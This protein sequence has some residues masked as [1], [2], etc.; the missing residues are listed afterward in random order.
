MA[1]IVGSK[2]VPKDRVDSQSPS[3][4]LYNFYTKKWRRTCLDIGSQTVATIQEC[5]IDEGVEISDIGSFDAS[6]DD[7][8]EGKKGVAFSPSNLKA[9]K[10]FGP[11][12]ACTGVAWF[13]EHS[14]ILLAK[15]RSRFCLEIISRE[16]NK[17]SLLSGRPV[18]VVHK[19]LPL[20]PGWKPTFMSVK[21]IQDVIPPCSACIIAIGNGTHILQFQVHICIKNVMSKSKKLHQIEG[22]EITKVMDVSINQMTRQSDIHTTSISG[23]IRRVLTLPPSLNSVISPLSEAADMCVLDCKGQCFYL[24]KER[25]YQ[26]IDSGP[27]KDIKLCNESF[28][29]ANSTD[30]SSPKKQVTAIILVSSRSAGSKYCLIPNEVHHQ[31]SLVHVLS[32]PLESIPA[33]AVILGNIIILLFARN[34]NH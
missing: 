19:I 10:Y 3:L 28:H 32:F 16:V 29:I 17:D 22:Y 13:G 23:P 21:L 18:P 9:T 33:N 31:S 8:E 2:C 5:K 15:R 14:I 26:L 27:F 1:V 20:P 34:F 12:A 11:L 24:T 4:W 6:M 25:T 30:T 7:T